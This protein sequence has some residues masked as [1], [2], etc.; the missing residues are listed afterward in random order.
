MLVSSTRRYAYILRDGILDTSR[1]TD[2]DRLSESKL[3]RATRE[4][5]LWSP[6]RQSTLND[7]VLLPTRPPLAET[8]PQES[9]WMDAIGLGIDVW[10]ILHPGPT[11]PLSP[12][13]QSLDTDLISVPQLLPAHLPSDS[14]SAPRRISQRRRLV[15]QRQRRQLLRSKFGVCINGNGN[16][17]ASHS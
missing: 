8:R 3:L 5:L 15:D 17:L 13:P 10:L 2:L 9:E 11:R 6:R 1:N 14:P 12:A 4:E 7:Q 16:G